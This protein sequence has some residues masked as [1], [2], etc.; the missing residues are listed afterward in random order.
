MLISTKSQ[1]TPSRN[2]AHFAMV[3]GKGPRNLDA[4]A[5]LRRMPPDQGQLAAVAFDDL[6]RHRH[7]GHCDVAAELH[8]EPAERKVPH[9]GKGRKDRLPGEERARVVA[10]PFRLRGC[11]VG[12]A[13]LP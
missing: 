12:R 13:A 6:V 5:L 7:L 8:A 4:E 9:G 2:S 3:S 1:S 11:V 10:L